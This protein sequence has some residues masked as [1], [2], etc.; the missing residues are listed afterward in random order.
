MLLELP[1]SQYGNTESA[2]QRPA[3]NEHKSANHRAA[4]GAPSPHD[5]G[6]PSSEATSS[7]MLRAS[8]HD[9]ELTVLQEPPPEPSDLGPAEQLCGGRDPPRR[10]AAD[11]PAAA[12]RCSHLNMEQNL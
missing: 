10:C 4:A 6:G 5:R 9:D 8:N 1:G 12:G 11:R 2:S 7:R 3:I